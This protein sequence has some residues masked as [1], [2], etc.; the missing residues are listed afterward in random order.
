MILFD[1]TGNEGILS[2]RESR[3]EP[4][5][6]SFPG[7]GFPVGM[8][9]PEILGIQL[10]V[11]SLAQDGVLLSRWSLFCFLLQHEQQNNR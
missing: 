1:Y 7:P 4:W 3:Y 5:G 11:H 10:R 8:S 6:S 2:G 9:F